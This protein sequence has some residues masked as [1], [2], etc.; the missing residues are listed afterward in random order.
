[1]RLPSGHFYK[2]PLKQDGTLGKFVACWCGM[3]I[4]KLCRRQR[5]SLEESCEGGMNVDRGDLS[6]GGTHSGS[7]NTEAWA[8]GTQRP[9]QQERRGL[10]SRNAEVVCLEKGSLGSSQSQ[11][12]LRHLCTHFCPDCDMDTL[13]LLFVVALPCCRSCVTHSKQV[14]DF[15]GW[16]TLRLH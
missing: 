2:L 13:C 7:R 3:K 8:A 15:Q 16:R 10:G 6:I 1:M 12:T 14:W 11:E 5:G 9:G 4:C